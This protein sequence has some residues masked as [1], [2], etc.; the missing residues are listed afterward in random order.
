M[1]RRTAPAPLLPRAIDLALGGD[2]GAALAELRCERTFDLQAAYAVAT[3]R[4]HESSGHAPALDLL[5]VALLARRRSLLRPLRW[6]EHAATG[7]AFHLVIWVALA[8]LQARAF[9]WVHALGLVAVWSVV[10]LLTWRW[11]RRWQRRGGVVTPAVGASER[12]ELARTSEVERAVTELVSDAE[13]VLGPDQVA[14]AARRAADGIGA[15]VVALAALRGVEHRFTASLRR[16]DR[17]TRRLLGDARRRAGDAL[18]DEL[19]AEL[20]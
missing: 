6:Y 14:S 11:V 12:S 19:R 16:S 10:G 13:A 8:G 5:E 17:R 3:R 4:R 9:G 1:P 18:T 2:L 7:W 20:R 15:E